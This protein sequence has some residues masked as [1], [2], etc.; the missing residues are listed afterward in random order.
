MPVRF[1]SFL[2]CLQPRS[3]VIREI[4]RRNLGGIDRPDAMLADL[5]PPSATIAARPSRSSSRST[6]ATPGVAS[7]RAAAVC[8][9]RD[10][11]GARRGGDGSRHATTG[12]SWRGAAGPGSR[13]A[14]PRSTIRSSSSPPSSTTSWTSTPTSALAWVEPGVLNLDL[15]RARRA[16]RAPLR[17]RPVVAAGVHDR[18]QRR[19]QRRRPALPRVR[20]HRDP[21]ARASRSCSPTVPRPCSAAW[22]PTS[23]ATTSAA[24][25]SAARARWASRP[26]SRCGSRRTRPGPHA[27][28]RLHGDR[29]R[30][31]GRERHHRG[32][33]R[34]G[35]ARDDGRGDHPRGRGLRRRRVSRAT[36]RPCCSSR[37]TASPTVSTSRV[38]GRR[39]SSGSLT[40]RGRCASR[41]TKP[42]GR[43][44]GRAGSRHSAR[45]PASRP[46]TTST[47]RSCRARSS[48]TC[49]RAGVRDRGPSSGSR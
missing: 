41:P 38:A 13:A 4:P 42:S 23:P 12:R 36:P 49:L 39:A 19:H 45:S 35:R 27:A 1:V 26:G 25:S 17:A 30:R 3:R 31:R 10:A 2:S 47:T 5:A 37:S 44:S 15:S 11:S 40:A 9:P 33:H 18:R 8:F 48:S 22:N 46:T 16:P 24:A 28:P 14:P 20:R 43:C 34:A 32:R 21:R 6:P 29:G 7:G